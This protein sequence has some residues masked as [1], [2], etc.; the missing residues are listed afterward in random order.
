MQ[1]RLI[2]TAAA[3]GFLA[4]LAG[5][6]AA[7]A[8]DGRLNPD[9]L[10]IFDLAARYHITHALA[11]LAAALA[12]PSSDAVLC[13]RAGKFFGAG[14]IFFSGSLYLLALTGARWLGMV[15]PIGGVC[16]LA[17]WAFLALAALR[18]ERS[19]H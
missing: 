14:I 5:T 10:E 4:V 11:M 3:F 9:R 2:A 7:H 6:F 1:R 13:T 15:T 18:P 12:I 16:F 19:A 8:L 17:G